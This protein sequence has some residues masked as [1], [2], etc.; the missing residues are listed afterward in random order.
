[1]NQYYSAELSQKVSRGM[2]ENRLKGL[3]QGGGVPYGYRVENQ[4]LVIDEE[5]AQTVKF[6]YEQYSKGVY[7]KD[8]ISEL[9]AKGI[10]YK[11]KKFANNTVYGILA[12]EKYSGVYKH[13]DEVVENMYPQIIPTDLFNAV[14]AIVEANKFGKRSIRTVYLLRN[15]VKC[16]YCGR[17]VSAETGTAR[18]GEVMHYYKCIGRKKDHN[19]CRQPVLKKEDLEKIVIDTII[20]KMSEPQIMDKAVNALLNL[21]DNQIKDNIELKIL[22]REKAKI[23]KALENLVTAIEQGIISNTTNKRLHELEEQQTELERKIL[24]ERSKC[25]VKLT[26]TMI[27]DYYESAL[28]LEPQMLINFLIKKVVLFDDKVEIYFNSPIRISPDESQ[29]FSFYKTKTKL[30]LY[31]TFVIL[32]I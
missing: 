1:M 13:K 29:G 23:D 22:Q 21:Q 3:Y 24:I 19:G 31:K 9:T 15:K 30:G 12:N 6:I 16:G 27:Q 25:T 17:P 26:K 28:R 8:I 14:R 7:V 11:G 32:I 20:E 5:K 10:T 2:R 4:K 18:N